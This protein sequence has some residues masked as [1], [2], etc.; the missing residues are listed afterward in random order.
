M[1]VAAL[2]KKIGNVLLVWSIK[3]FL[4]HPSST[5]CPVKTP[6][7]VILFSVFG[8]QYIYM[9]LASAK[10][11]RDTGYDGR[12]VLHLYKT[13]SSL[14]NQYH[15]SWFQSLNVEVSHQVLPDHALFKKNSAKLNSINFFCCQ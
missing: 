15:V 2:L 13:P 10:S 11:L 12:I 1:K 4:G 3:I 9:A 14:I 6:Q 7:V 8:S 5:I